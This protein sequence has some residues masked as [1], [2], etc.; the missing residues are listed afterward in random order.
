MAQSFLSRLYNYSD[1]GFFITFI[2]FFN[3]KSSKG[4]NKFF[5]KIPYFGLYKFSFFVLLGTLIFKIFLPQYLY[6]M[7]WALLLFFFLLTLV[8]LH[9]IEKFS[10]KKSDNFLAVY[11]SAM[12]GR[13]FICIIF[14]AFF[15]LTDRSHVFNFSI[16]YLLLYLLFLGFEINGIMTNLRHHF[17]KGIGN[18]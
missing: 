8:S 10:K 7:V 18:E 15:I 9:L 1:S 6:H 11:F 5:S 3:Q 13:L 4:L 2:L 14:A 16:N 12:I 17:K